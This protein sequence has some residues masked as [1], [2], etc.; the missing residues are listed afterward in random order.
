MTTATKTKRTRARVQT[1]QLDRDT[2]E[3]T[4]TSIS[5]EF[6]PREYA[7]AIAGVSRQ[8]ILK[9]ITAGRLATRTLRIGDRS[10][11]L[12]RLEDLL[13]IGA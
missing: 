13:K 7:T 11:E 4:W 1:K 2:F 5:P 6:V 9:A 3:A 12:V 10:F 8:A